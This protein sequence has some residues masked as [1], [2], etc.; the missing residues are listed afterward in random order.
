MS[1]VGAAD[2]ALT[3]VVNN[4]GLVDILQAGVTALAKK[5]VLSGFVE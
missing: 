1:P 4:Q 3:V 5:T 2:I